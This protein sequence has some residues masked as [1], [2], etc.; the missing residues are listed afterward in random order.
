F[1]PWLRAAYGSGSTSALNLLLEAA[2]LVRAR[3]RGG[4]GRTPDQLEL[5]LCG[6]GADPNSR[7]RDFWRRPAG[8]TQPPVCVRPSLVALDIS[9]L[10][11]ARIRKEG[12]GQASSVHN[13]NR[14]ARGARESAGS[15]FR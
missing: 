14:P 7:R 9:R 4:R 5:A 1:A 11:F 10:V 12:A 3:R 15:C 2:L 13:R 6:R 8:G